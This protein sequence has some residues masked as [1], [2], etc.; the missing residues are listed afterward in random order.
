VDRDDV[1]R[2]RAA[3]GDAEHVAA[4]EVARV[5]VE[6]EVRSDADLRLSGGGEADRQD[7]DR[8]R[9]KAGRALHHVAH[10]EKWGAG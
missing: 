1:L 3:D 4:A 2:V 8:N 9:G 10:L 6:P 7:G 5:G